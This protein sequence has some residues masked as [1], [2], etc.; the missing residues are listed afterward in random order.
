MIPDFIKS[1][2]K[3]DPSLTLHIGMPK[4]GSTVLQH[5]LAHNR[6]RL[7]QQKNLYPEC[8]VP[9]C[10]HTALVKSIG[11]PLFNWVH[12]NKHIEQFNPQAYLNDILTQC[13]ER[14]CSNVILSSEFFWAAPAMQ[15]S[16]A[17]RHRPT[18]ENFAYIRRFLTECE[19][20][21][22]IFSKTTI[23]VYLRRQDY[24]IDSFLNQQVKD[25]FDIPSQ[26]DLLQ[27]TKNYLLYH[28]NIEILAEV[29]GRENIVIRNYDDL[30]NEDVVADFSEL[31]S[32]KKHLLE[33]APTTQNIVNSKLSR[34]SADIMRKAVDLEFNAEN[35]ALFRSVLQGLSFRTRV[36]KRK[37]E[38]TLFPPEFYKKVLDLYYEDNLKLAE[39]YIDFNEVSRKD[40]PGHPAAKGDYVENDF[41][42]KCEELINMLLSRLSDT[43]K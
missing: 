8:G 11:I 6:E 14:R 4:T 2:V 3:K 41:E 30:L 36:K 28:K 42:G 26:E 40:S 7:Q 35:L 27:E 37:K 25:G 16:S 29:F 13:R 32:L 20:L 9:I 34:T 12:F 10:Q 21:F 15:A 38:Y 19:K 1:I 22:S 33:Q 43:G 17:D 39:K 31:A 18:A 24:W 23:V 5:F